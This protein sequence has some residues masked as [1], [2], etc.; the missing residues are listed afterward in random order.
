MFTDLY[1]APKTENTGEAAV[2][3]LLAEVV[4]AKPFDARDYRPFSV[5]V[6]LAIHDIHGHLIKVS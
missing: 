3:P 5:T 6:S 4:E 2:G 1:D